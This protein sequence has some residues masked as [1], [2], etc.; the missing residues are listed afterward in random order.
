MSVYLIW[1]QNRVIQE[2]RAKVENVNEVDKKV[3]KILKE[4]EEI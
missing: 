2:L 4:L 1:N 3:E